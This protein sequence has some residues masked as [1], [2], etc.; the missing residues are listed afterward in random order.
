MFNIISNNIF[1]KKNPLGAHSSKRS[2]LLVCLDEHS[3][4]IS[5]L[6]SQQAFQMLSG[7]FT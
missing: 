2:T 6:D 7:L 5:E 1:Y 4:I 3:G